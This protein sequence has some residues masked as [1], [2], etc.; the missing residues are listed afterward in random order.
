MKKKKFGYN[1]FGG[2]SQKF[3]P[4]GGLASFPI[5]LGTHKQQ[6]TTTVD[7]VRRRHG[8]FDTTCKTTR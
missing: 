1:D 5:R 4:A 8:S 2:S 6:R 3:I 7:V